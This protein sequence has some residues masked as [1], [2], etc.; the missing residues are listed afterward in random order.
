M[1]GGNL[2]G[3]L[4]AALQH[5]NKFPCSLSRRSRARGIGVAGSLPHRTPCPL[6]MAAPACAQLCA[7]AKARCS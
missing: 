7:P 2:N 1:C 6:A 3:W 4:A 5:T